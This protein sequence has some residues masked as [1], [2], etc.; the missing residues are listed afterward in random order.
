MMD[1]FSRCLP[2]T[3]AQRGLWIGSKIAPAGSIFNVAEQIEI[4]GA[5]DPA[6][7]V[8]A[9][10]ETAAETDTIRVRVVETGEGVRQVVMPAYTA[11]FPV[12]DVSQADDP[13]A[14]AEAWMWRDLCAPVDLAHDHLWRSVLFRAG[15]ERWFWYH[16]AHHIMFDGFTGGLVVRRVA[17]RYSALIEGRPAAACTFGSLE[18][19]IDNDAAYR[20]SPRFQRDRSF[21]LEHLADLPPAISL[22]RR[23]VAGGGGLRRRTTFLSPEITATLRGIAK[24]FSASLPQVLTA[25][26]AAYYHRATG[27]CDLVIGM[28]V[29]GRP[30]AALRAIPGMVANAVPMRLRFGPAMDF[31][32]LVTEAGRA[33][34]R[35]LRH[36]QFRYEELRRELGLFGAGQ[37]VSWLGVNIEPFDYALEFGGHPSITHNLSNG[38]VEDL[39]IFIYDRADAR[40][41]RIDFDANPVLY[42][43]ADLAL[44]ES[45]LTRLIAQVAA[46]PA[47]RIDRIDLFAPGERDAVLVAW[48]ATAL[49][50]PTESVAARIA[51]QAA[52]TPDAPA[53]IAGTDTLTYR[54]LTA[55]AGIIAAHLASAG[56]GPGHL[57]GI[58][59]PRD[60]DLPAALLGVIQSGAAWLPLDPDQP[61]QRLRMILEDAR[62]GLLVTTVEIAARLDAPGLAVLRLDTA[63]FTIRPGDSAIAPSVP[64][65]TAYVIFTSGST[66]RPKGVIVP[67]RALDNL[68]ASFETLLGLT[69]DDRMLAV[70]T[71][72]FDIAALEFLLPL[73]SG[74]A[75]VLAGRALVRDPVALAGLIRAQKVTVM[76]ATPSLYRT[77]L[78]SAAAPVAGLT[79]LVGGEALPPHLATALHGQA[80]RLFNVYGPTETTIWSTAHRMSAEDCAAPPIGRPIGNTSVYVLDETGEP[81]PPCIAGHLHIGGAGVALGYLGRPALDAGTFV[82]DPFG[83]PGSR[84][85]RTGDIARFCERG[86]LECLG[87]SDDQIKIRGFRVELGE[88]EAALGAVPEVAAAAV[89]LRDSETQS[90]LIGYVVPRGAA[91]PDPAV[92]RQALAATLPDYMI[93][94]VFVVLATLPLNANGKLDRAALP[95]PEPASRA[96]G[97]EDYVAPRTRGETMLAGLW[98]ETFGLER[99]SVHDNFFALGGDSLTA[100]RMVAAL[101]GRFSANLPIGALFQDATIASLAPYLDRAVEIDP[102]ATMLTLREGTHPQIL[103]CIHPVA[104]LS[105]GYAGLA[106]HIA[107][108]HPIHGLQSIGFGDALPDSIEAIAAHYL[109][110]MRR[111]QENG[112]YLLVGWSLGGLIAHAIA[113][114]LCAAGETVQLLAMLDSYPFHPRTAVRETDQTVVEASLG[115]LGYAPD[116]LGRD[117]GMDELA[118]LLMQDYALADIPLPP[119]LA[120]GDLAGRVRRIAERT[121]V[122]AQ[123]FTPGHAP[124][125][126]LFLRAAQRPDDAAGRFLDDR[127]EAWRRH[128]GGRMIVHDIACRHQDMLSPGPLG[129][130]GPIIARAIG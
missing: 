130:I 128:V 11:D 125:D 12:H 88:I 16:C 87:R 44:H 65:E 27:A 122:L 72:G 7:F 22:A 49:T 32:A 121:L 89:A 113:A 104:G 100:A 39:M 84:M 83:V 96:V 4:L 52:H 47:A 101:A 60:A 66:G 80:A 17:E 20:A 103:F 124:V 30:S 112:P 98:A 62:P 105:W 93:P 34:L 127:P 92:L 8:Q 70:T 115:F 64:A 68:C 86:H 71:V 94:A 82:P 48:N 51:A 85:F 41:L 5:I 126:L 123:G 28:P 95:A 9:L 73:L 102:L 19:L 114:L 50:M 74:A 61:V 35:A 29:T 33:M 129:T 36:Q 40:G 117:A 42:D 58:A 107:A 43:D 120:A 2:L 57:V 111:V 54:D 10:R 26:V 97:S 55:R 118:D 23:R 59:L 116:R 25:L 13:R 77:L 91:W 21:W 56:I 1:I 45:R 24:S 3:V 106:P 18:T 14:E 99:V 109:D 31:S 53:V 79:V 90:Q 76:Q 119:G 81:V 78:N 67:R 63:D 108:R 38:S 15:P 37:Q 75:V 6:R 46:N 69:P 110:A